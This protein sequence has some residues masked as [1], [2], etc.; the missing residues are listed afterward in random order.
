MKEKVY[1]MKLKN[2]EENKKVSFENA[3]K[4]STETPLVVREAPVPGTTT[5]EDLEKNS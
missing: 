5:E 2:V 4:L 1:D 3:S